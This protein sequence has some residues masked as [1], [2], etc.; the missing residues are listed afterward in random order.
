[1]KECKTEWHVPMKRGQRK[2]LKESG[3]QLG[4]VNEAVDKAKAGIRALVEHP[5]RVIK[6]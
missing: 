2:K 5:F 4:K 1:M 3:S 6:R